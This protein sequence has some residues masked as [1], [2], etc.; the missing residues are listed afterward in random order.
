MNATGIE[1]PDRLPTLDTQFPT[2]D[3]NSV[4]APFT[5]ISISPR[6]AM[7]GAA[8]AGSSSS[9]HQCV[10]QV[11]FLIP[12]TGLAANPLIRSAGPCF[13]GRNALQLKYDEPKSLI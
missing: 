2:Y 1:V 13:P 8:S 4:S 3:D 6:K 12:E 10:R 7:R 9:T 5:S 11:P